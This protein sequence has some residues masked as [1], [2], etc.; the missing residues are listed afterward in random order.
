MA[1]LKN[2]VDLLSCFTPS[3]SELTV[4]EVA[5]LLGLP[6]S[7]VSRLMRAMSEVGMLDAAD[8]GRGYR[9]GQLLQ[10]LGQVARQ[11]ETFSARASA[12][13]RHLSESLGLTSYVSTL[14]GTHMVG[15]VHH[16]GS[17]HSQVG[18][19]LGG[20]LP[21]DACATGRAWLAELADAEVRE[22]LQNGVS[23]ATPQSPRHLGDLLERLQRV[24]EQGYAESMGEAARGVEALAVAVRDGQT[25]ERLTL[26]V[27]FESQ[28]LNRAER[29]KA[30]DQLLAA[31]KQLMRSNA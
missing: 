11:G 10:D 25:G 27:T 9:L 8:R 19:P 31:R 28:S 30:I 29:Q 22:L 16:V 20:R 17:H 14:I 3:R 2:A 21:A 4:T 5:Q 13:A 24:R 7:N 26:C 18:A 15:L 1:L 23:K 6:K 12:A